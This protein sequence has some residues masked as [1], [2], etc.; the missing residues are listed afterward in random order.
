MDVLAGAEAQHPGEPK[1][2]MTLTE[3]EPMPE[4]TTPPAHDWKDYKALGDGAYEQALERE[5]AHGLDEQ[6]VALYE[7]AS[8]NLNRVIFWAPKSENLSPH[9]LVRI[10]G[11]VA[12]QAQA[13]RPGIFYDE[14]GSR[15][16]E[17]KSNLQDIAGKT[18]R[19]GLMRL[20]EEAGKVKESVDEAE[21]VAEAAVEAAIV[22]S[23]E[24]L[25][26]ETPHRLEAEGE[27]AI[28]RFIGEHSM[29]PKH[30]SEFIASTAAQ[31]ETGVHELPLAA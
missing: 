25:D 24:K 16:I 12:K 3:A 2:S 15:S 7:E 28:I 8:V 23:K 30:G 9:I 11:S 29:D 17:V 6:T 18:L 1:G 19:E 27:E 20:I 22:T 26:K 4:P 21:V 5:N 14:Y 13:A 10:A 31:I